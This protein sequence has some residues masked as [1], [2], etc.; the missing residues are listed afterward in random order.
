MPAGDPRPR[1]DDRRVWSVVFST[2]NARAALVAHELGLFR[3]LGE[4]ARSA[5]EVA[6]ALGIAVRPARS[7]LSACAALGFVRRAGEA[8]ALTEVAEDYLLP[9]S[10]TYFGAFWD[11]AMIANDRLYLQETV[12]TAVRSDRAQVYDGGDLFRSNEEQEALAR[13]FTAMMHG[14]S[15]AP[16]L[17]WP[18]RLDLAAHRRMLD[19]GGGSGAHAIGAV[20]RWPELQAVVWDIPPVCAVAREFAAEY[21]VADRVH[22]HPGDM[23]TDPFPPADLHFYSDVLH[24]WAPERACFLCAK[25]FESLPPGGRIVLHEILLDDDRTGPVAAAAYGVAMLLWTE[26]QQFTGAELRGMLEEI[27]F[28]GVA[29]TPTFGHWSIVSGTKP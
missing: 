29:I 18:D 16:A 20:R 10:P 6:A 7:L 25:S 9:A 12:R 14:H 8:W 4:R 17:A 1:S 11:F 3:V 13:G 15:M 21:G 19:V 26:G 5:D 28:T 24:D 23:W 27:G 2:L 22:T